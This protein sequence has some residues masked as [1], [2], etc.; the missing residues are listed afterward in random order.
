MPRTKEVEIKEVMCFE[1]GMQ[2]EE[3]HR[4]QHQNVLASLFLKKKKKEE[5]NKK[6]KSHSDAPFL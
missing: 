1:E 3:R 5:R 4:K 2:M 6:E